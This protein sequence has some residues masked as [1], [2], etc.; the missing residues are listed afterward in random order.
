MLI[1]SFIFSNFHLNYFILY[2]LCY[3]HHFLLFCFFWQAEVF[4]Y[5]HLFLILPLLLFFNWNFNFD[6]ILVKVNLWLK[7]IN[8]LWF[9]QPCGTRIPFPFLKYLGESD[10]LQ[11]LK[12]PLVFL[13]LFQPLKESLLSAQVPLL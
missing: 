9:M 12:L 1:I 7:I 6:M 5:H 13:F 2:F 8:Q 4:G 11:L 3:L 10:Q